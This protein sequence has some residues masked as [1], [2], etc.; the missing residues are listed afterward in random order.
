MGGFRTFATA[1]VEPHSGRMALSSNSV[2]SKAKPMQRASAQ[3]KGLRVANMHR[4]MKFLAL[5][6]CLPSGCAQAQTSECVGRLTTKFAFDEKSKLGVTFNEL[7][8]TAAERT[9]FFRAV[10]ES[11]KF[12]SILTCQYGQIDRSTDLSRLRKQQDDRQCMAL[13]YRIQTDWAFHSRAQY[14][15]LVRTAC[16]FEIPGAIETYGPEVILSGIKHPPPAVMSSLGSER[17]DIR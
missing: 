4:S 2:V 1:D 10:L 11:G 3:E 5:A 9:Q 14:D 8:T 6:F 15:D 17:S 13:P 12:S 7:N 16:G